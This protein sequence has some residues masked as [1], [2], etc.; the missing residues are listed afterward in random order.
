M[1]NE[2]DISLQT[3]EKLEIRAGQEK[4]YQEKYIGS[5]RPHKGHKLFE[6]NLKEGTC[7]PAEFVQQD[8]VVGKD[9]QGAAHK[10]VLVK[11]DCVY[12]SALNKENAI[13]KFLKG[14]IGDKFK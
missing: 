4:K 10:K 11:P 1:M 5:I 3:K 8:Y 13:R 12:V 6:I 14:S 2:R 7:S 9:N